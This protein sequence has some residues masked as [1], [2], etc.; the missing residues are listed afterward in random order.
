MYIFGDQISLL[1]C[2]VPVNI[3]PALW[4]G[5][6]LIC[7]FY[8][9][10]LDINPLPVYLEQVYSPGLCPELWARKGMMGD[11]I[12]EASRVLRTT[13]TS[14]SI[15]MGTLG[16]HGRKGS[17]EGCDRTWLTFSRHH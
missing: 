12:R 1:F 5:Y 6:L 10:V 13:V 11:E 14:L 16:S 2:E 15:V 17:E 7:R 9:Y 3:L 8:L 4:R